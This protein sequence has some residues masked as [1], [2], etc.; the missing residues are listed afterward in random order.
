MR[1]LKLETSNGIIELN[2]IIEYVFGFR[3]LFVYVGEKTLA[4]D[5]DTIKAAYRKYRDRW[6]KVNM[7][8]SKKKFQKMSEF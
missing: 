5:R 7:K 2:D 6:I 4:I 3:F 8:S 1:S